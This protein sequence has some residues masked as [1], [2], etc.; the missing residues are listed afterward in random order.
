MTFY[1]T[2]ASATA[3]TIRP[4]L[5][6]FTE[7]QVTWNVAATGSSWATAGAMG[8]TDRGASVG[9]LQKTS[10]GS[11]TVS[12]NAAG[13][14]LVQSWVSGSATNHGF[15][16]E[17]TSNTD[18]LDVASSENSTVSRRPKLAITYTTGVAT[19]AGTDAGATAD[20]GSTADGGSSTGVVMVGAG[21]IA[22]C[23][24]TYDSLTANLLDTIPGTIFA[25]GDLAYD[26]GTASEFTNCFHP[27]WG[28][29]KSRIR[30]APGNHEYVTSGA[31]GYYN[32]FGS[33]AGDPSKGY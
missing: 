20:A 28:R 33:A 19:D 15:I 7:N 27:T 3:Y 30:P 13:I 1:V 16:V 2:N 11:V 24:L 6:A 22:D 29:H 12:L 14:A 10:T 17:S 21:D 18:G 26:S 31:S 5:R 23:D 32:Y 4:L 9:T 8:A 25:P